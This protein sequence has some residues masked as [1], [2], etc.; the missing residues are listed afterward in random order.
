VF[1]KVLLP[2]LIRDLVFR[3]ARA[4]PN[5]VEVCGLEESNVRRGDTVVVYS[6]GTNFAYFRAERK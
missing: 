3:K 4:Y 5:K 1:L 6:V 2:P